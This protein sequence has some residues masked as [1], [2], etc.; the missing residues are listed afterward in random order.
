[1]RANRLGAIAAA[2]L[3]VV[4][5]IATLV[6]ATGAFQRRAL[7]AAILIVGLAGVALAVY[8]ALVGLGRLPPPAW[9]WVRTPIRG[10]AR[11]AAPLVLA[12]LA[13]AA[14]ALL[15]AADAGFRWA[16]VGLA[17]L[18]VGGALAAPLAR[19]APR[20]DQ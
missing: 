2:A 4:A 7:P 11:S 8:G 16:Y 6:I 1:M 14:W 12:G 5:L 3:L 19:R 17:A 18:V 10:M 13:A 15:V 20:D 9:R